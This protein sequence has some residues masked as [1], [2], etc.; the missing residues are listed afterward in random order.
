[1][2][3]AIFVVWHHRFTQGAEFDSI[4]SRDANGHA[5]A[6]FKIVLELF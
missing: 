3:V 6:A 2:N 4:P 1:M 5:K